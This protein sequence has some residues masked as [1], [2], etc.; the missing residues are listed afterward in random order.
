MSFYGAISGGCLQPIPD[1]PRTAGGLG[2]FSSQRT[3]ELL[4]Q[5]K[6]TESQ[7]DGDPLAHLI[8]RFPVA[9]ADPVSRIFNRIDSDGRWPHLWKTE[10]LTII[11]KIPNPSSLSECRNI[12]CTSAFSKVLE[13]VILQQLRAELVPDEAQ[14]GGTPKCGAE[15]MLIDIWKKVLSALEGGR[16]ASVL[17]GVDYEKAFNRM[18]HSVCLDKLRMLGA[19]EGSISLVRAFLEDRSMT[20]N[21]DGHRV[22]PVPPRR[23]SPQ[24]SVLGCLLYC[25]TTQLLT[26]NL[27]GAGRDSGGPTAF[28]YVDDT[29]LV[30]EALLAG[31]SRHCTTNK[32]VKLF[33]NLELGEDFG[34]LSDRA[35]DIWMKINEKKTQLL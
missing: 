22:A 31:A 16:S 9:F 5:S 35:G 10:H 30:D 32:T 4:Q 2:H 6:K 17:L 15:H 25:I 24:S 13:G 1:I 28:L 26:S 21:I 7:V 11:P 27:R 12:S 19:S 8:R 18:E 33:A 34:T 3:S 29:T 23:G 20:I 14:Y